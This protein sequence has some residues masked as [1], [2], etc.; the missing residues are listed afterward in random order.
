[1]MPFVDFSLGVMGGDSFA[2]SCPWDGE[3][4]AG[5]VSGTVDFAAD[6]PDLPDG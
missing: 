6:L 1:M 5:D 2:S 3:E 4:L